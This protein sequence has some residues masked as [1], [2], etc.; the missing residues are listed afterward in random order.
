MLALVVLSPSSAAQS[1][2]VERLS[3]LMLDLGLQARFVTFGR[4]EIL[5]N[6]AMVVPVGLL[7]MLALPRSRWQDWAAY[8]FLASL[9]VEL[10]QGLLLPARSPSGTDVVANTMGV[11]AGAVAG[12]L[13]RRLSRRH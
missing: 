8:G 5:A 12:V 7:G 3:S 10:V 2:V 1:A 4:L 11:L 9:S 6:V 13:V